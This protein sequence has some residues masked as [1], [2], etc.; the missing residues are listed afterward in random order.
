M[1]LGYFTDSRGRVV[2]EVTIIRWGEDAFWIMTAAVAQWHDFEFL[3]NRLP[4][5]GSLTLTDITGDWSTALVTGPKSRD[6]LGQITEG[7]DL[8]AGWLSLGEAT[9]AGK[10][11]KLFRVSFAGELGWEVHS[12]FEDSAAVYDAIRAAGAAPF[13]MYALNS[14]RIEKGYRTWKGDL[15]TDYT[16][17]EA[18]LGRFMRL[19]K[20]QDFPGKAALAAEQEAGPKKGF[21]T[22]VV[23]APDA[24][25]PYMS[26][27][28]LGGEI[29]GETTSGDWGYRVNKSIALGVVAR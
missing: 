3:Q 17:L 25:A 29:V 12:A 26:P 8:E 15:S 14:M 10:P 19:G 28:W 11:V 9:L 2:T 1:N 4:A 6:L 21:V 20:E 22:L 13:G 16:L 18:G 23:D 5:D 7:A 27:I 24:D